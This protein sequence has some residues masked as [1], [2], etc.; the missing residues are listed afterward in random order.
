MDGSPDA[1]QAA[2]GPNIGCAQQAPAATITTA[3]DITPGAYRLILIN[4][5]Y[6]LGMRAS[7]THSPRSG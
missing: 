2:A 3:A 6:A 7:A 1:R 4:P 5:P